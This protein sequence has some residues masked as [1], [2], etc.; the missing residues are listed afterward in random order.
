MEGPGARDVFPAGYPAG[1]G[2]GIAFLDTGIYPHEDFISGKNR[3]AAFADLV[4][5]KEE[6][7][8]DNG[9]G[10]HVKS[11]NNEFF[12]IV[13]IL[14]VRQYKAYNSAQYKKGTGKFPAPFYFISYYTL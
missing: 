10:T 13:I 14:S 2:V 8:D 11:Q 1:E 7:Y 6:P 4:N 5:G 9:H 3:I 12:N